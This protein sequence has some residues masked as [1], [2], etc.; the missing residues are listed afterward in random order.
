MA[1]DQQPDRTTGA[2]GRDRP[3]LLSLVTHEIGNQLTVIGG[4]AEMLADGVDDLPP[5]MVREFSQAILRGAEQM[6]ALLQSVSDLRRLDGGTIDVHPE[7]VDLAPLVRRVVDQWRLHL[8]GRAVDIVVPDELV[9]T[10]DPG[11]VQQILGNLLSNVAKHTPPGATVVVELRLAGS[12][13]E[14]SVSDDGPGIAPDRA[15]EVFQRFARVTPGGKGTGIGLYVAREVARAHG[16]DLV[17]AP[18]P[19]GARFVLRLPHVP[20]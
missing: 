5:A 16:G 14:L 10:A 19:A 12:D 7:A 20:A 8:G 18:Q 9:T 2:A 1:G 6:R 15:D 17:L 4:F 3:E 11:R 13:V